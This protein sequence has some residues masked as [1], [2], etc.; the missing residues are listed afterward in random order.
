MGGG[1]GTS[2][3]GSGGT[4]S[5]PDAGPLPEAS[6]IPE[7]GS[8]ASVSIGGKKVVMIGLTSGQAT[9]GDT[10]MINR[11]KG[12]G[13]DVTLIAD[14]AITPAALMNKD[15]IILSSSEESF[16]VTTKVRDV[17]IPVLCMEDGSFPAMMMASARGHDNGSSAVKIVMNVPLSAGL[18][19]TVTISMNPPQ[20]ADLGWGVVGPKAIV[21]ATPVGDATHAALFGYAT[22]DDMVGM[23]APARRV[24]YAVREALAA[25]FT[26]DGLKLFDAAVDWSLG[27]KP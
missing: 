16:N 1:A 27:A 22:G 25:H 9:P 21:A 6:A 17:V 14:T 10:I 11:L 18:T 23:K 20:P 7:A 2:G 26:E 24:G 8:E 15:L 3:A 19:G 4:P 12:R 5:A 13:L